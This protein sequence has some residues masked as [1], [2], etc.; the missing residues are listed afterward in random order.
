MPNPLRD[1]LESAALR[2]DELLDAA[3]ALAS[4]QNILLAAARDIAEALEIVSDT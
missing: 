4:R 2:L 3:P 1:K